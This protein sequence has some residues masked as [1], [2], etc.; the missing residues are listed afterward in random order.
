MRASVQN[1]HPDNAALV[2]V[3]QDDPIGDLR[4]F[5]DGFA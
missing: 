1:L 4:I 3:V 5:R 2:V